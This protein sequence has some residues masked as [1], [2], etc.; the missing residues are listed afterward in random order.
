MRN[1]LRHAIAVIAASALISGC[2]TTPKGWRKKAPIIDV[3]STK[4]VD[5]VIRCVSELW[6]AKGAVP[7]YLP[8]ANGGTLSLILPGV[9]GP[10]GHVGWMVDVE[11]AE[12]G[13]QVRFYG[14]KT[15]WSK[16]NAKIKQ[17]IEGCL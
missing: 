5:D 8:R 9:F 7:S 12:Q 13:S 1:S 2:T 15:I 10:S 17:E 16:Q 6:Q 4:S 3:A 11:K 14:I